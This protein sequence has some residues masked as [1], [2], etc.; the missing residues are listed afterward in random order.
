ML[1]AELCGLIERHAGDAALPI[2]GLMLAKIDSVTEPTSSIA[3]ASLA[4]VAQGGKR[5][6]IGDHVVDYGAG[7][8]LVVSVDLPVTGQFTAASRD[9][10]FLGVGL[11]LDPAA[12]AAL[13]VDAPQKWAR[14]HRVAENRPPALAATAA[15]PA[16]LDALVRLLR[17]LDAPQDVAVLAPMFRREILWRL[18]DGGCG[19]LVRQIGTDGGLAHVGRAIR[20][21][22]ENYHEPFRV[23]HLA[24]QVGMSTSSFHRNFRAATTMGPIQFQKRIRL[25]QAR[26]LLASDSVDITRI[27]HSVGY[28]SQS[29]FSREYRREFGASPREDARRR[30]APRECG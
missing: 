20:W 12:V 25:Q 13:L 14:V 28:E 29:Q 16:L 19:A 21:I 17:L 9:E 11:G 22:R 30:A 24:D 26:L 6:A 5:I 7:D 27:A 4:F 3:E 1:L 18:L 15:T 2:P 23:D 8:Y 10:P